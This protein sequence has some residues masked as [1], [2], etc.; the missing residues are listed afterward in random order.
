MNEH[1]LAADGE[2]PDFD[3]IHESPVAGVAGSHLLNITKEREIFLRAAL[4]LLD[5]RE[6]QTAPKKH[7]N[8]RNVNDSNEEDMADVI[9]CG[10]IRKLHRYSSIS[11]TWK[12]KFAELRHGLFSYENESKKW[13][14]KSGRTSNRK[15]KA[16]VLSSQFCKCKPVLWKGIY[17]RCVFEIT[18]TGSHTSLFVVC[19]VKLQYSLCMVCNLWWL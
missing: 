13:F 17:A 10:S 8:K 7:S 1:F 11:I 6:H 15:K 9:R 3:F 12:K 5:H 4:Q 16:I 14:S 18:T 2:I 19:A